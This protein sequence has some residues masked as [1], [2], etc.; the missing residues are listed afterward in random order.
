MRLGL[1]LVLAI[2][3]VPAA[4]AQDGATHATTAQAAAH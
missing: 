2:G 1:A 4:L 3:I